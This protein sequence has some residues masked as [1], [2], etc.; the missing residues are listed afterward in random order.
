MLSGIGFL[1]DVSSIT[2]LLRVLL[3]AKRAKEEKVI[4]GDTPRPLGRGCAP[5]N[6][7]S[8]A[9]KGGE[10]E[11]ECPNGFAFLRTRTLYHVYIKDELSEVA[12]LWFS[13]LL[14]I[15]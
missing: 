1:E 9:M 14:I 7:P 6:P 5:C 8:E 15:L 4:L 12:S 2:L 11:A 3:Q 10:S 13:M